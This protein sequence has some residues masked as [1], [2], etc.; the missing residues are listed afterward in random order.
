MVLYDVMNND[1]SSDRVFVCEAI[2]NVILLYYG[3]FV[4]DVFAVII[5]LVGV[6]TIVIY[7]TSFRFSCITYI[8]FTAFD[9][10][11]SVIWMEFSLM[12]P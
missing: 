7:G 9:V 2:G 5:I 8:D 1:Q 11:E 6:G 12:Q 10:V 4:N 3:L